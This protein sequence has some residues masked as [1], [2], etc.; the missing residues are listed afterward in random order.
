MTFKDTVLLSV[1]KRIPQVSRITVSYGDA[2][3][4]L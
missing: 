2:T 4:S 1:E 3:N